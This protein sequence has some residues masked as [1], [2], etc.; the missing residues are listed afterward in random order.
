[1]R[2]EEQLVSTRYTVTVLLRAYVEE[3]LTASEC[4]LRARDLIHERRADV[5]TQVTFQ[6]SISY[7][8]MIWS[9]GYMRAEHYHDETV[10]E[11]RARVKGGYGITEYLEKWELHASRNQWSEEEII[12][13]F[14][15]NVDP[16]LG[17]EVKEARPKDEK[18]TT[19]KENLVELYKL[20]DNKYSIKDL[21]TMT[22]DEDESVRAFGMRFQKIFDVLM[23]KGKISEIERC[24]IF[25]GH[26]SKGRQK[27]ILKDLPRDKLDFPEVLKLAI[28]A[29][30]DDYKDLVWKWMRRRGF[31]LYKDYATDRCPDFKDYPWSEKN[32]AV[33]EGVKEIR[34]MV[35]GLTRQQGGSRGDRRKDSRGRNE[36]GGYS[37]SSEPYPKSPDPKAARSSIS[38]GADDR[39]STLK[40]SCVYCRGEDH[41]KRD[42]P[43]LKWA[44]D[45]GLVVLDDRKYVKW[46][47]DLGDVSMFPSMKENV[48]ARR[49]KTS[50]GMEP[51]R[52]QS[53]KIIFEGDIAT[54][55]I[56]VAATKS[57]RGST[58]KKT[59]TDYVMTEKDGQRVDGE[60]VIFSPRKWGVKKFLMKSSLDKID[61][62]EPLRRALRQPM[63]CS[64]LKYLAASKSA[65]DELQMITQKTRIPL[66]EEGEG[67]PK[68]QAS[69]VAVTGVTAR[70]DRKLL[71]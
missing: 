43:D 35:K 20:E 3:D 55:P 1:M 59:D 64:I 13:N 44:I 6:T 17:R 45:E 32:E 50:K 49:I 61:T 38:S 46:A 40:N 7:D 33:V 37:V 51:V 22:Q 60:E 24:T 68:A 28:K 4:R 2:V 26:L 70:A 29:E 48:E 21:E 52:S 58:L 9:H 30:A 25:I 56:R 5:L 65:R 14:L 15:F 71:Q 8:V 31:S 69:T 12:E 57:A 10:A 39:P 66:S 41:I 47:D 19:Y 54:T 62:V 27:S 63:Q 18:W 23:K 11:A 42:C 16:S 34:D 67:A 53:I 36:R